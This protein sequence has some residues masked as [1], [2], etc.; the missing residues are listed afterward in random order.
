MDTILELAQKLG[1]AIR[2]DTRYARLKEAEKK[3]EAD[4]EAGKLL[5]DF[6]AQT[7]KIMAL[8]RKA[9]PVEPEDKRRMR[10]LH[11]KVAA[12]PLIK[13]MAKARVEYADLMARVNKALFGSEED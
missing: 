3:V 1:D 12:H 4:A 10:D 9:A 2:N 7:E 6:Q 8:E 11:E 5:Q 13:E